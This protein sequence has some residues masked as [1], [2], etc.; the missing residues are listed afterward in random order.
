MLK[1]GNKV[2]RPKQSFSKSRTMKNNMKPHLSRGALAFDLDMD[3]VH[4][5]YRPWMGCKALILSKNENNFL[6]IFFNPL[7]HILEQVLKLI[8]EKFIGF[9]WTPS[10]I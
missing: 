6:R 10:G 5:F 3:I 7:K 8:H 4:R 2:L 1:E 9:L